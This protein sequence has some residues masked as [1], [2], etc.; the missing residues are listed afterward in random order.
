MQQIQLAAQEDIMQEVDLEQMVPTPRRQVLVMD[1]RS[2]Q[3]VIFL[4][5][6]EDLV[7]QILVQGVLVMDQQPAMV[8]ME[9]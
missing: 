5:V 1:K 7:L 4:A 8:L 9:S 6:V 2:G 3:L